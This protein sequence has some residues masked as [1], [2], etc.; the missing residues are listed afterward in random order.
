MRL[1]AGRDGGVAFAR[2]PEAI[3]LRQ[4]YAAIEPGGEV[5]AMRDGGNPRCPVNRS[6]PGQL[7]PVFAA[8]D[9]AVGDVLER[10]TIDSLIRSLDA[11]PL[12]QRRSQHA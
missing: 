10:T 6:M 1:R 8:V 5:F 2:P 12:H 3:T 7:G 11:S 9:Q 4:V